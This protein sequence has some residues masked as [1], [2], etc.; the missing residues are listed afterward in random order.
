MT[1]IRKLLVVQYSHNLASVFDLR[2]VG[3]FRKGYYRTR[4]MEY[5]GHVRF[6]GQD[7]FINAGV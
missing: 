1:I 3:D 6:D 5:G 4:I 7:V 2:G